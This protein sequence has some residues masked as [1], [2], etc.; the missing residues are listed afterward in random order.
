MKKSNIVILYA[1]LI[2]SACTM[3]PSDQQAQP[4]TAEQIAVALHLIKQQ[5]PNNDQAIKDFFAKSPDEQKE[6]ITYLKKKSQQ[7]DKNQ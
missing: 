6:F 4:L 5:D 7:Q 3:H 1:F 2:I